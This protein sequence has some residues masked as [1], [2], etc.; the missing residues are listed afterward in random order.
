VNRPS[1]DPGD[2]VATPRVTVVIPTYNYAEVLGFAIASVLGQTFGD[3]ELLVVGDG[4]TDDSER[5][6]AADGH[7]TRTRRFKGVR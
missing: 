2:R 6:T 1:G 3:F 7:Q 5:V 4:C